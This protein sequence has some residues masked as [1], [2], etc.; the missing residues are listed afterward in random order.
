MPGRDCVLP[1]TDT[2]AEA[3]GGADGSP[4]RS[5]TT[6]GARP[7]F[8]GSESGVL[9]THPASCMDSSGMG[10]SRFI[11]GI[12]SL[13]LQPSDLCSD[14]PLP[15]VGRAPR[16]FPCQAAAAEKNSQVPVGLMRNEISPKPPSF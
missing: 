6:A 10:E 11:S 12:P 9:S 2:E 5:E 8:L 13:L 15:R 3:Q 4:S 14:F 7:R 1:F 16:H